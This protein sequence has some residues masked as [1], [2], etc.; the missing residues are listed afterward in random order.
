LEDAPVD[1]DCRWFWTDRRCEFLEYCDNS[2]ELM[3]GVG[4]EFVVT[5]AQVL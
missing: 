5:A 2:Q 4:A 1:G 3:S